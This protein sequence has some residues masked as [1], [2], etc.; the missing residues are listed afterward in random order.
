MNEF[1][2]PHEKTG[3]QERSE[4]AQKLLPFLEKL[5]QITDKKEIVLSISFSATNR[6]QSNRDMNIEFMPIDCTC[7][8]EK[9]EIYFGNSTVPLDSVTQDQLFDLLDSNTHVDPR[10]F[11]IEL[12]EE[13]FGPQFNSLESETKNTLLH[14]LIVNSVHKLTDE[15]MAILQI[16][17][18][19]APKQAELFI[20]D[21]KKNNSTHILRNLHHFATKYNKITEVFNK[22]VDLLQ[23][24]TELS[25][26]HQ[27]IANILATNGF[28]GNPNNIGI[29]LQ[30]IAT[31]AAEAAKNRKE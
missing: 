22:L 7:D 5:N 25:K 3:I 30:E 1:D 4:L 12:F 29:L 23:N 16:A 27:E 8:L 6:S 17:R 24:P 31:A 18:D 10:E 13:N 21:N 15:K 2:N 14:F 28:S 20:Q 11:R 19:V 9:K 26:F